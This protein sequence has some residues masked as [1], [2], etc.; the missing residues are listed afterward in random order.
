MYSG[1]HLRSLYRNQMGTVHLATSLWVL[2]VFNARKT[3]PHRRGDRLY[4]HASPRESVIL[5][6]VQEKAGACY[7]FQDA[8]LL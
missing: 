3:E 8:A 7:D 5:Q 4:F 6:Q 2:R 1:L